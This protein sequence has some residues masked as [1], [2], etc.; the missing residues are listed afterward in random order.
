MDGLMAGSR[1]KFLD[2]MIFSDDFTYFT[3]YDFLNV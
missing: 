2:N 3:V 1:N